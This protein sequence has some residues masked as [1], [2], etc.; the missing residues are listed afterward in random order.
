MAGSKLHSMGWA[1]L[2]IVGCLAVSPCTGSSA[3]QPISDDGSFLISV[4][5][6]PAGTEKFAVHS[7]KDKVEVKVQTSLSVEQNG[8]QVTVESSSN[9]VL[10]GEF[11]PQTYSWKQRG[12]KSSGME[13]DFRSSPAAAKYHTVDGK[14]DNRQIALPKDFVVLDDNVLTDYEILLERYERTAGG[15]Q[16]ITAFIPQ[17]ALPGRITVNKAGEESIDIGNRKIKATHYTATTDLAAI[18]LWADSRG[19]LLRISCP[20]GQWSA[21]RQ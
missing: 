6:K 7:S 8:N 9:L 15:N 2:I 13:I 11:Q 14:A 18:D 12:A 21:V 17:E 3:G 1:V 16:V 10:D 20:A 4:D 19:R 5:G